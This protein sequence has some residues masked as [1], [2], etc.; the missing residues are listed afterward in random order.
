MQ[1]AGEAEFCFNKDLALAHALTASQTEGHGNYQHRV[2]STRD[3]ARKL[4][5]DLRYIADHQDRPLWM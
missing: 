2:R 4:K 3:C 1:S 5:E